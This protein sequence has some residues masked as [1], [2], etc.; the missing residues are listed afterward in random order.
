MRLFDLFCFKY[1]RTDFHELNL[2][3][4]ISD[5]RTLAETLDNFVN[6]NTIKYADP[7][8]W[9]IATQ[10]EMN[11][12]VVDPGTAIAYISTKPVPSGVA[13][14]N[15]DY[16]SV[17]FSLDFS[18]TNANITLRDDGFNALATFSSNADDWLIWNN[19]L[20][21]VTQTIN[22]NEAY[23]IGYNITRYTV[24]LFIKDY[25]NALTN[26][27][28]NLNN[29]STIDKTSIVNALNELNNSIGDLNNLTTTDKTSIVNAINE[30]NASISSVDLGYYL[31]KDTAADLDIQIN[32]ALNNGYNTIKIKEGSYN[33]HQTVTL[34]PHQKIEG[35]GVVEIYSDA[36][37]A[38]Q[39][40]GYTGSDYQ[41][42]F[43]NYAPYN[44]TWLKNLFIYG[45]RNNDVCINF[46]GNDSIQNEMYNTIANCKF[47]ELTIRN[48]YIGIKAPQFNFYL[49]KF[50]K[51]FIKSCDVAMLF[52]YT[53]ITA[54]NYGENITFDKCIMSNCQGVLNIFAAGFQFHF[55][56]CSIDFNERIIYDG[57][58]YTKIFITNSHLEGI[59]TPSA[60][61][62]GIY[63]APAARVQSQLSIDNCTIDYGGNSFNPELFV[64]NPTT[65]TISNCNFVT[66][67]AHLDTLFYARQLI[68]KSN[69]KLQD[70]NGRMSSIANNILE[71][72]A[73][74]D[75]SI[76]TIPTV[77]DALGSYYTQGAR[78]G[79]GTMTT[80]ANATYSPTGHSIRCTGTNAAF[81][82]ILIHNAVRVEGG[83]TYRPNLVCASNAVNLPKVAIT[84]RFLYD[85]D[86]IIQSF[87]LANN[88]IAS[89][90]GTDTFIFDMPQFI[91]PYDVKKVIVEFSATASTLNSNEYFDFKLAYLEEI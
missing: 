87:V 48:F 18:T 86:A 45:I 75:I 43:N 10:Y 90:N 84:I 78:S 51:C 12:V 80:I 62:H 2:D 61:A 22:V 71:Y 28:G 81:Q 38:F 42:K 39:L 21:K 7:I 24:E 49:N 30:L 4:I 60:P 85:D 44:G 58:D 66:S 65:T 89:N 34:E 79:I 19:A 16:W 50:I 27:I 74:D 33:L 8:Q 14:T 6:L 36:P 76:N 15:T 57:G 47:E 23:V 52:G 54:F 32:N 68:I 91:V 9:N 37:V 26:A 70:G 20:Y 53:G 31:I 83:C 5:V 88:D 59:G 11:T 40:N 25:I 1:N 82:N 17:I 13:I 73:F 3:W 35:L 63:Y 69:N 29:L 77:G 64:E 41:T 55:D 72:G 46:G 67:K 56:N